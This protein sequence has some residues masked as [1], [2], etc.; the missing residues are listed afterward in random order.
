M[1]DFYE[2]GRLSCVETVFQKIQ[3]V[4]SVDIDKKGTGGDE[5]ITL[6]WKNSTVSIC[7]HW[8]RNSEQHLQEAV[9]YEDPFAIVSLNGFIPEMIA[10]CGPFV[11]FQ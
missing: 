6:K 11:V 5:W 8:T 1:S 3:L 4:V 7:H 9:E 10:V 2:E